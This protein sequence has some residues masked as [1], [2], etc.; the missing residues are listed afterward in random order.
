MPWNVPRKYFDM[1]PLQDIELPPHL[2]NDLDDVPPA[3]VSLATRSGDHARIVEAGRWKDAVQGYLAAISYCDAMVGGLLDAFEKS[4]HRDNTIIC[5][6]SD[7]GWSLGEKEHWRKF[8]LWD[9]PTRT[10]FIWVVPG[11]T[12]PNQACTR[13]VDLMSIYP[14]LCDLAGIEVP[15]HVQGRSIRSLLTD[16][17]SSWDQPA[18]TTYQYMNHAIRTE[19]WRYIQYRDGGEELYGERADPN[20]WTNLANKPEYASRKAELARWLPK[21]NHADIGGAK[22]LGAEEETSPKPRRARTGAGGKKPN[23]QE[24]N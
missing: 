22:G 5:F 16:P 10:P 11:L 6:W 2:S 4:S 18:I 9:E 21:V 17:K 8:A 13:P 24:N 23:Q 19:D 14:T 20:E 7:H 3:G 1:H 12:K 15:G